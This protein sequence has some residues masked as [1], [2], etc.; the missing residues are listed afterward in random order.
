MKLLN[1]R[2]ALKDTYTIGHLSIDGVPEC[3]VLEDKVRDIDH[4]G[5][6]DHGESKVFA[7]TAIPYGTYK[8]IITYSERFKKDLPLL[9]NVPS[10]DGIRIHPGNTSEDT[11]GCLLVGHNTEM[12]KVT[13]SKDTFEKLFKKIKEAFDSNEEIEITIS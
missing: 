11:H 1:K 4:D 6:F 12:G 3:D 7:E 2:V 9:L 10:F 5:K 8:I 13:S